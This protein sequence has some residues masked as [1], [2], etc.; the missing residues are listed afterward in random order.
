MDF[1]DITRNISAN[2]KTAR[3]DISDTMEG[4]SELANPLNDRCG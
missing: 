3:K 4:F 1:I 2:F